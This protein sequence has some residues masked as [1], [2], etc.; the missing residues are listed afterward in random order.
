MHTSLLDHLRC[1]APHES[2]W[3]V[4][5]VSRQDGRDVID[6]RLGCP[7]CRATYPLTQ[8]IVHLGEYRASPPPVAPIPNDD[9]L[10]R[11]AALL[12]LAE[13]GGAV[14]LTPWWAE[15][16]RPLSVLVD[17]QVVLVE[18]PRAM[19]M[20]EGVAGI[21]GTHGLPLAANAVRGVALDAWT[22][23]HPVALASWLAA[24]KPKGRVV[25]PA[26]VPLPDGVRELARDARH[27]VGE[28]L[29]VPAPALVQLGR[30][31]S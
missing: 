8:G 18:P 23:D 11:L 21:V 30:Q 1:P 22:A 28:R 19:T 24:V 6:G 26:D 9:D 4:A 20:V 25:A 16:A 2:T 3:L 15:Y 13:P 14:A 5:T 31:R 29:A 17:V 27:W 7:V 12:H 10:M